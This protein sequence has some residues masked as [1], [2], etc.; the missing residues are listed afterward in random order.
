[1]ALAFA[2]VR[3]REATDARRRGHV[4][5]ALTTVRVRSTPDAGRGGDVADAVRARRVLDAVHTAPRHRVA[6][7]PPEAVAVARTLHARVRLGIAHRPGR[8]LLP[9]PALHAPALA[10]QTDAEV[11]V[12]V[13]EAVRALSLAQVASTRRALRVVGA[14]HAAASSEVAHAGLALVVREAT[15]AGPADR[16]AALAFTAL[17]IFDALPTETAQLGATP[18]RRRANVVGGVALGDASPA[19]RVADLARVAPHLRARGAGCAQPIGGDALRRA[20]LETD[21]ARV[22]L[23]AAGAAKSTVRERDAAV[24]GP[25]AVV[26]RFAGCARAFAVGLA[27]AGVGVAEGVGVTRGAP[28]AVEARIDAVAGREVT[29]LVERAIVRRPAASQRQL[30]ATEREVA[31]AGVARLIGGALRRGRVANTSRHRGIRALVGR[32]VGAGDANERGEDDPQPAGKEGRGDLHDSC[33]RD[34]RGTSVRH[35]RRGGWTVHTGKACNRS[36]GRPKWETEASGPLGPA[37]QGA[38]GHNRWWLYPGYWWTFST[39]R[40]PRDAGRRDSAVRAAGVRF[41]TTLSM[42]ATT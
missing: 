35:S 31:D 25:S 34:G 6:D 37:D 30:A 41:R 36:E 21:G 13:V 16:V 19:D 18:L 8:A 1:M 11:T 23:S 7:P 17:R 29:S 4:A 42:E 20:T 15:H 33:D 5:P 28:A 2:A 22:A 27:L 9:T 12:P 10:G 3:V 32:F 39:R 24:G 40:G 38:G 14:L 26:I